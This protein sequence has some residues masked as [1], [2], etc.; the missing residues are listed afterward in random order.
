MYLLNNIK[1]NIHAPF[2]G[3]D[4]TQYPPWHFSDP[5]ARALAG[6][7]EAPDPIYPDPELYA[8]TEDLDGSLTIAERTSE[9]IAAR[10]AAKVEQIKQAIVQATQQRLDSFAQTRGYDGIL[11][12]CTYAPSSVP[13]FAAEGTYAVGARD[14]TWAALYGVMQEVETGVLPMPTGFAD[15]ESLLPALAWPELG[16]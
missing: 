2:I 16:L 8:Y 10:Q 6:V 7:V 9:D 14:A 15:V 1:I 13:K 11:S 12:A 3:P 4:G 5:E